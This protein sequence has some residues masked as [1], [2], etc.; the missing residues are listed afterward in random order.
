LI[1]F[2]VSLQ[3]FRGLRFSTYQFEVDLVW[4]FFFTVF[5]CFGCLGSKVTDRWF[6]FPEAGRE[7]HLLVYGEIQRNSAGFM[8]TVPFGAVIAISEQEV[9]IRSELRTNSLVRRTAIHTGAFTQYRGYEIDSGEFSC[10]WECTGGPNVRGRYK[11]EIQK[12]RSQKDHRTETKDRQA[13]RRH[14]PMLDST[15]WTA[16]EDPQVGLHP[17]NPGCPKNPTHIDPC[18]SARTCPHHK[19]E[20]DSHG[21]QRHR[22]F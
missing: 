7:R 6:T 1:C 17:P 13:C 9:L 8:A 3:C 16:K 19:E 10:R 14:P 21:D 20:R 15:F 11:V 2:H 18:M 22:C 5:R 12:D 4:C